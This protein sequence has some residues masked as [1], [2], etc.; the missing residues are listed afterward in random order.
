M[1]LQLIH[2][3]IHILHTTHIHLYNNYFIHNSHM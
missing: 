1:L 3:I 2:D